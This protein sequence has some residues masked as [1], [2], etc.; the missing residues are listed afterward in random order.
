MVPGGGVP[1]VGPQKELHGSSA[2]TP[3]GLASS[4]EREVKKGFSGFITTNKPTKKKGKKQG[5][6]IVW[7]HN[8]PKTSVSS[9]HDSGTVDLPIENCCP[10][11]P[12]Y[13]SIVPMMLA[14]CC[15]CACL[16]IP[17]VFCIHAVSIFPRNMMLCVN[18]LTNTGILDPPFDCCCACVS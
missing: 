7:W 6:K 14:F 18:T 9:S 11:V 17:V 1:L 13:I 12:N 10:C 15:P 8:K 5:T 4:P 16:A 3:R 2:Y